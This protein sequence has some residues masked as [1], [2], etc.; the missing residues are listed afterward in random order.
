MLFKLLHRAEP[1]NYINFDK[2]TFL[3]WF[4][5]QQQPIR[6]GTNQKLLIV[7]LLRANMAVETV[8]SM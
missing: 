7:E 1:D 6:P 8:I 4:L 5:T 2:E 3:S